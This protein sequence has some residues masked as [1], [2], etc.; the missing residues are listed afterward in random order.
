MFYC[1]VN[2]KKLRPKIISILFELVIN[3]TYPI[4]T[5]RM[6]Q[7]IFL[8]EWRCLFVIFLK[9]MTEC[10]VTGSEQITVAYSNNNSY[11][12]SFATD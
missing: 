4:T 3:S 8:C 2:L 5:V 11:K 7:S 9:E 10:L 6:S 12:S 1:S